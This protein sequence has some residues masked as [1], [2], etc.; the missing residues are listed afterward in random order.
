M[1]NYIGDAG[2]FIQNNKKPLLYVG[3]AIAVVVIG[4]AIVNRLKSGISGIFTNTSTGASNFKPLDLDITKV[5]ISDATANTYSNQLF[6]AMKDCGTDTDTIYSVME[7][8]QKKDD[9]I[10]VYNTF[11]KRSYYDTGLCGGEPTVSAYLFGYADLDLVEWLK[12]EVGYSN[13]LT[14]NLVKKTITNAGLAF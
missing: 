14:Y 13:L 8:L 2:N 3:G 1:K 12:K 10:K 7:K 4:Y 5:T 6:N 9:F 11:G